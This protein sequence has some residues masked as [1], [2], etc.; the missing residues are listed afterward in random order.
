MLWLG[1]VCCFTFTD[2]RFLSNLEQTIHTGLE[3]SVVHPMY[4]TS[5]KELCWKWANLYRTSSH[6]LLGTT[7]LNES[8][9]V[10]VLTVDIWAVMDIWELNLMENCFSIPVSYMAFT[11]QE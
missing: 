11:F 2:F 7:E 1:F 3:M 6:L 5:R 8:I 10:A 4:S 9:P